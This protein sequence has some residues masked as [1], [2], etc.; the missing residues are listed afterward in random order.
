MTAPEKLTVEQVGKETRI[1]VAD[2][3]NARAVL[4][5]PAARKE[6]GEMSET[7]MEQFVPTL[8]MFLADELKDPAKARWIRR[9]AVIYQQQT[10]EIA[11]LKELVSRVGSTHPPAK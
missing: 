4:E 7:N 1:T 10:E 3:N 6:E 9:A 11:M 2:L 5:K 8:F